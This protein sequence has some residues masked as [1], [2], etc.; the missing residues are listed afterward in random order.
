VIFHLREDLDFFQKD[1]P[2]VN[3]WAD[4]AIVISKSMETPL[5]SLKIKYDVVYNSFVATTLKNLSSKHSNYFEIFVVGTIESRKGQ[6]LAIHALPAL[7]KKFPQLRLNIVGTVLHSEKSYLRK[8]KKE[9]K[10]LK[11]EKYVKFWGPQNEMA[12]IYTQADLV[13][14]PSLAEPFGRV[15]IE[16]GYYGKSVICSNRGGLPEIVMNG[17][18]GFV[19]NPEK[20]NDLVNKVEQFLNLTKKVKD[21]MGANARNRVLK[22]FNIETMVNKIKKIY[23][24]E[25]K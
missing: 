7:L 19:F 13:L 2:F 22:V 21:Q 23:E 11:I 14:I 5:K 10:Q 24:E 3:K 18:T 8:L 17:K 25:L 1:L 6:L 16:A 15:A 20:K 12:S 9:I 4:R